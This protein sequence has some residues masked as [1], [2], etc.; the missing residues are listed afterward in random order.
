[1][2]EFRR[3]CFSAIAP[4][5][6]VDVGTAPDRLEEVP[7]D[8]VIVVRLFLSSTQRGRPDLQESCLRRPERVPTTLRLPLGLPHRSLCTSRPT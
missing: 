4:K 5:L 6:V 8:I 3:D 2:C 1:V 7:H